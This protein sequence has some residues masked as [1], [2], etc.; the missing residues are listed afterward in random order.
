MKRKRV[1]ESF[2]LTKI[3]LLG[4]QAASTT[5]FIHH[6]HLTKCCNYDS[7]MQ[8]ILLYDSTAFPSYCTCLGFFW[9]ENPT[10]LRQTNTELGN[11][12]YS[13]PAQDTHSTSPRAV[14]MHLYWIR[15]LVFLIANL[16]KKILTHSRF[17]LR[18]GGFANSWEKCT[19]KAV[20]LSNNT[21]SCHFEPSS[22]FLLSYHEKRE[23]KESCWV[24]MLCTYN[25]HK[26]TANSVR[27]LEEKLWLQ[28]WLIYV[29]LPATPL[30]LRSPLTRLWKVCNLLISTELF[31]LPCI[32][33]VLLQE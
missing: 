11:S 4:W 33:I 21:F 18:Q 32:F 14:T 22:V 24:F 3:I 8:M 26:W 1:G 16:E 27:S 23:V 31:V 2:R 7:I 28:L 20:K 12:C 6:L 19:S 25:I 10:D 13:T 5:V 30:T 15:P 9:G 17:L 29:N